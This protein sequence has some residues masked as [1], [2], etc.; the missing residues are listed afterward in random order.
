M[1]ETTFRGG[2]GGGSVLKNGKEEHSSFALA[3]IDDEVPYFFELI[4]PTLRNLPASA[5]VKVIKAV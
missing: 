2:G 3:A 4:L 1:F 5:W